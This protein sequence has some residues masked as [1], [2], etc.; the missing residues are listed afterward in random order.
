M[1]LTS[2]GQ[3]SLQKDIIPFVGVFKFAKRYYIILSVEIC[4]GK[5]T[6][7]DSGFF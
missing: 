3:N 1:N 4:V 7:Q 2:M 6:I 5:I